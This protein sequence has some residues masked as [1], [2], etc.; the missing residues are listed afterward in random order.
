[1]GASGASFSAEVEVIRGDF[2]GVALAGAQ[3]EKL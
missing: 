2:S 3:G 1:M